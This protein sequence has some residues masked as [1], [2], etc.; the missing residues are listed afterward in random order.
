ME[1]D[2]AR[3]RRR[4]V[5]AALAA[6]AGVGLAVVGGSNLWVHRAADGHLYTVD[7]VPEHP[8]AIVLGAGLAPDGQP[9][10][11][12]AARLD[13]AADLVD[14][15]KVDV[16]LVS[17]DNRTHEYDEPTA[18]RD[19]LVDHGVPAWRVVRD[20]AGRDSYDTCVRARRV[21]EVPNAVVVSQAYHVPRV[22]AVCR[23]T[24]LEVD[25]VGDETARRFGSVWSAGR[26]RE[27]LADVKA[28][29]DVLS[30]REPILG[31]VEP[32]V[33]DALERAQRDRAER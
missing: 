33:R 20:Y 2:P 7:D 5:L 27:V 15:G 29:A 28:A 4:R 31:E 9:S 25:A 1:P 11:F 24:G 6:V 32:G 10:P 26:R 30:R 16:V 14:S 19:Y 21:F 23:A 22:V 13:I 18:M 3:R 17:G 12:L 8:V